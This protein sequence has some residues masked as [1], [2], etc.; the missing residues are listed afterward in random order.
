M[1]DVVHGAIGGDGSLEGEAS[2]RVESAKV[3]VNV[4]FDER[5]GRPSVDGKV[6]I[7]TRVGAICTAKVDRSEILDEFGE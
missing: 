4:I 3:L 6:A 5:V 7:G 1:V 2:R